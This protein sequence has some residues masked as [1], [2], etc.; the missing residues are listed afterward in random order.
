[1]VTPF[2]H[3]ITIT[4]TPAQTSKTL[5]RTVVS[6]HLGVSRPPLLPLPPQRQPKGL[7]GTHITS[8]FCHFP[9]FS[10][11]EQ[12]E[13]VHLMWPTRPP[14]IWP[15][16]TFPTVYSQET[17]HLV[18]GFPRTSYTFFIQEFSNTCPS[19]VLICS[20]NNECPLCA[21]LCVGSGMPTVSHTDTVPALGESM[22][23]YERQTSMKNKESPDFIITKSSES[24]KGTA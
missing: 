4:T 3:P 23:S 8:P 6:A 2:L 15:L 16:L 19:L 24:C 5:I 1:M 9:W 21:S 17:K 20:L 22:A 13:P 7:P 11:S 12:S 14:V 10:G 18:Q